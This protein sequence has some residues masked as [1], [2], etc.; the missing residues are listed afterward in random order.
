[1][2]DNA[3]FKQRFVRLLRHLESY[4]DESLVLNWTQVP[5]CLLGYASLESKHAL[6]SG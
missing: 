2:Q 5:H 4:K 6:C 1:M 3:L